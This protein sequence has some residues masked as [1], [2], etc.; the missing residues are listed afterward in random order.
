MND[1]PTEQEMDAQYN[2]LVARGAVPGH[3]LLTPLPC[4]AVLDG[5]MAVW[6]E[7]ELV[8]VPRVPMTLTEGGV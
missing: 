5:E 8:Y 7:P 4:H 6:A 1:F 3:N 2:D